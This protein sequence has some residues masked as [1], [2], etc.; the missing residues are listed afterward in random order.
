MGRG[1][2]QVR[3]AISASQGRRIQGEEGYVQAAGHWRVLGIPRSQCS[4]RRG[5]LNACRNEHHGKTERV[6]RRETQTPHRGRNNPASAATR[7]LRLH[8]AQDG[9]DTRTELGE[10]A[11]L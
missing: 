2:R 10:Y 7:D 9:G 3:R 11:T 1:I 5:G 4:S 6:L 8:R